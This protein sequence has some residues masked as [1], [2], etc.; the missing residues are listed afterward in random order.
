MRTLI[1]YATK[2]GATK[3]IAESIASLL[4]DADILNISSNH[5]PKISDYDFIV[6]G[7]PLTAGKIRKE[8][9]K[10]AEKYADELKSKNLGLYVSGLQASGEAECF[11]QNFSSVLLET[12]KAKA[13]LGGIFDPEKCGFL[14]RTAIKIIAKLDRYTST[15]DEEEIKIFARNLK[16]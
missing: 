6:L 11:E 5:N 15:I 10:F 13:F 12:A 16:N 1:I 8:I 4:E 2:Y 3:I 9:K 14:V 7:S